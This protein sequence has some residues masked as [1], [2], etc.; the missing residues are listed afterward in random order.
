MAKARELSSDHMHSQNS[1]A[2][3]RESTWFCFLYSAKLVIGRVLSN[4][5][6]A[7]KARR[8]NNQTDIFSVISAFDKKLSMV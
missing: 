7:C 1:Y 3:T 4:G 2:D 6:R 8:R 5:Y